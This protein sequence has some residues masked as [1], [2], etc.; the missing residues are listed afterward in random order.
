MKINIKLIRNVASN[1]R[2]AKALFSTQYAL[3]LEYRAEIVLWAISGLLP[4]I[5]L[6]VWSEAS[7]TKSIGLSQEWINKY[8]VSA[9]IVRQFTAVWVMFSFEEDNLEGRLSPYLLQPLM[10]FW[11]YFSSHIAEQVTRVPIVVL[12]LITLNLV[13]NNLLWL[14]PMQT[15]LLFILVMFLAFCVRFLLH[16]LCSMICF[17]SDR[18]SALERLLLIPYLFLS[19]LVAPLDSF[20][21]VIR[22]I[23][24]ATPFPYILS[25][26]SKILAGQEI[27]FTRNLLVLVTWGVTFLLLSYFFWKKGVKHYSGMGA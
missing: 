9:F 27:D 2:I 10:P 7:I 16:W 24:M 18:A 21:P 14:P 19:G 13:N 17:W 22:S 6:G 23:A 5:M 1:L 25:F 20:P 8:F 11:R 4:L 12:M 15:L 3:M 26:P